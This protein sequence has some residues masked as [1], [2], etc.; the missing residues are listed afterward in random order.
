MRLK[1]NEEA[2]TNV[3]FGRMKSHLGNFASGGVKM[4]VG[5][6]GRFL[7]DRLS[8]LNGRKIQPHHSLVLRFQKA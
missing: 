1:L 7:S 4:L 2:N 8:L 5:M 6:V 3:G